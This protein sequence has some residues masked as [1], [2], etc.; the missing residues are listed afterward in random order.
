MFEKVFKKKLTSRGPAFLG[1]IVLLLAF[2]GFNAV[3]DWAEE[4]AEGENFGT[5]LDIDAGEFSSA[6]VIR[7]IDGDTVEVLVDSET[8]KI[9]IIGI[10]TPETVD[11]R[12]P[13]ECFGL[14]AYEKAKELLKKD[15]IV[16]L[17]PDPSQGDKDRYSRLLRYIW[18]DEHS[19]FGRI[20]I[21]EG[22]AYEY[23]YNLPYKYQS[24]YKK[25]QKESEE[26]KR[27]LWADDACVSS[28][29][30]STKLIPAFDLVYIR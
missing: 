29:T 22:Y 16:Y 15:S 17:E 5:F 8:H 24:I 18:I 23:T 14:E 25:A 19:D 20:M 1:L 12:K 6:K 28:P 4:S 21:E 7:V 11:P 9:R 13:V 30:P 3:F 10:D 2:F 26:E 27:G